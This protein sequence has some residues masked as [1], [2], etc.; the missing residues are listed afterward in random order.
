VG[1]ALI[2]EAIIVGIEVGLGGRVGLHS[3][4]QAEQF[5]A[6]KCGMQRIGVDPAYYHLTYFEYTESVAAAW[7]QARNTG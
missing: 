4:P 7:L 3:L 1:A 2:T 6:I 5:Y